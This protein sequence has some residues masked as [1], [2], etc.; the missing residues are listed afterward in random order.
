MEHGDRS[1]RLSLDAE[2]GGDISA[3]MISDDRLVSKRFSEGHDSCAITLETMEETKCST[4]PLNMKEP[5]VNLTQRDYQTF[6]DPA[7]Q[8]D[9]DTAQY[10]LYQQQNADDLSLFHSDKV[11]YHSFLAKTNS[12]SPLELA[13]DMFLSSI[14][15]SFFTLPLVF[16]SMGVFFASGFFFSLLIFSLMG[17]QCYIELKRFSSVVGANGE[18]SYVGLIDLIEECC[19]SNSVGLFTRNQMLVAEVYLKFVAIATLVM[20]LASNQAFVTMVLQ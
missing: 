19:G 8:L 1:M 13:L 14:D 18:R 2:R 7:R 17:A 9:E 3:M 12:D 4:T 6:G 11:S 20:L 15:I 16:H 5:L 10:D